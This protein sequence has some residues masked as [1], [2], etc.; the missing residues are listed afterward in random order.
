MSHYFINDENLNSKKQIFAYTFRDKTVTFKSDSGVFAKNRVDFGTHVLLQNLPLFISET[1]LD[2][3][4]GLG[5]IGLLIAKAHPQTIV[6]LVDVNRRALDLAK[7]SAKD[8]KINNVE[9]FAS[10]L[11]REIKNN[12]DLIITNPPIRAG[13]RI[14]HAIFIEGFNHLNK[15]GKIIAVIQKKQGAESLMNKME[16]IYHNVSVVSKEKGYFVLMSHK[17]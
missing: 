9:F 5:V 7:E 16:D 4:C 8:N 17:Q 14:V 3:G 6:H 13:K 12:Y 15:G 11:Y 1:I 10:D 2:M